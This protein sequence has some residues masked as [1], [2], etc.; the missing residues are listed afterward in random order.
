MRCILS[1]ARP[2]W[3]AFPLRVPAPLTVSVISC[4]PSGI[5]PDPCQALRGRLITVGTADPP[6]G[7]RSRGGGAVAVALA[8]G[9]DL[10]LEVGK[11]LEA[12]VDRGEPE[13]GHL[14]QIPERAQDGQAHLV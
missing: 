4:P 11:R 8:Q 14:V 1:R 9:G 5:R 7:R 10:I 6:S 3:A 12:S 13:V 2:A